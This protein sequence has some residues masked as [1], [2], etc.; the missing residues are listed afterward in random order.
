VAVQALKLGASEYLM[1]RENYCHG[2][3][4]YSKCFSALRTETKTD[5][6]ARSEAQYRLLAENSATLFSPSISI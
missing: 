4:R 6:L 1:K 5:E 3:L 2:F